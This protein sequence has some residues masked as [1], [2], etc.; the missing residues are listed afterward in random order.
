MFDKSPEQKTRAKFGD[1]SITLPD[2]SITERLSPDLH[3]SKRANALA[4]S[5]YSSPKE[6]KSRGNKVNKERNKEKGGKKKKEQWKRKGYRRGK[7][8]KKK[9]KRKK[10]KEKRKKKKE[11]R[12]KESKY[13]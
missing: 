3:S 2:S 6:A 7:K 11:K 5:S 4:A 13:L 9:E 10:R 1:Q 8:E 12:K